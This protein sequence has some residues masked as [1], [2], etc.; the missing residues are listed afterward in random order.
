MSPQEIVR[1]SRKFYR[2]HHLKEWSDAIPKTKRPANQ[3]YS[4]V[5]PGIHKVKA[6]LAKADAL[7]I[8]PN[9]TFLI[10]P[11]NVIQV[12]NPNFV[13]NT[14]G[15]TNHTITQWGTYTVTA[16]NVAHTLNA[17]PSPTS[18]TT[19]TYIITPGNTSTSTTQSSSVFVMTP[20]VNTTYTITTL[21][22]GTL[23]P[24]VTYST[25]NSSTYVLNPGNITQT[26]SAFVVSPTVA[27]VYT[28]QG[29]SSDTVTGANTS[30]TVSV[31]FAKTFS[32]TG[33]TVPF[34]KNNPVVKM[35]TSQSAR[36]AMILNNG[37][38]TTNSSNPYAIVVSKAP[39]NLNDPLNFVRVSQSGCWTDDAAGNPIPCLRICQ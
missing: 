25:I 27:T 31:T 20:S 36:L 19:P 8:V 17:I 34:S 10:E 6:A 3:K 13:V 16:T 11:S 4:L 35:V 28:L 29:V 18:I 5:P 14:T 15:L 9:P 32:T 1:F 7:K 12:G 24:S 22:S 30:K 23:A 2:Q 21:N 38:I 39:L 26:T 33:S 37:A